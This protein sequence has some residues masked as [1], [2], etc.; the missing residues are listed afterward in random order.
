MGDLDG[1]II[2]ILMDL[3]GYWQS[4][5][6]WNAVKKYKG[7]IIDPWRALSSIRKGQE[8]AGSIPTFEILLKESTWI[9]LDK[10]YQKPSSPGE[11]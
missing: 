11:K 1:D 7:A 4:K 8:R 6:S 3:N 10:I 5:D 9:Q 2:M